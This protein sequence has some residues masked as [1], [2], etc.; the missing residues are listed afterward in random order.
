M[1]PTASFASY[2]GGPPLDIRDCVLELLV[3]M[4]EE[5][6]RLDPMAAIAGECTRTV[7]YYTALQLETWHADGST[8][9]PQNPNSG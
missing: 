7:W 4:L 2:A 5:P 9:C 1:S 6:G 8:Y 3:L